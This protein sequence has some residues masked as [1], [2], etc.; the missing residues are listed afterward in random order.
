LVRKP[1][2]T[3]ATTSIKHNSIQ[4]ISN[5]ICSDMNTTSSNQNKSCKSSNLKKINILKLQ[6]LIFFLFFICWC[7]YMSIVTY[8]A[9]NDIQ[10]YVFI[11]RLRN[12]SAS[13]LMCNSLISPLVYSYRL[14]FM[15]T[16]FCR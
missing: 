10:T 1:M 5:A 11:S 3:T 15:R 2:T 9:I 16:M 7:P 14:K 4:I 12:F 6:I 8:E 13:F